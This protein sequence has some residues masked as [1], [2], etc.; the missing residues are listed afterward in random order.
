MSSSVPTRTIGLRLTR[1]LPGTPDEVYDAYTDPDA[2][3]RW[4]SALG[5]DAGHVR[6]DVDLRVGGTWEA[7]FFANPAV[8]VHDVFTFLALDPPRRLVIRHRGE[9]TVDGTTTPTIHTHIELEL[10]P[11][12]RGSGTVLTLA[13]TGFVDTQTRDFFE[14][15][16][17][18]GGLDRLAAYL[19]GTR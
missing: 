7:T 17:W 4:L 12:P 3:R 11:S 8:L 6:T 9:S 14:T 16:A 15:A 10:A 19:A 13:Q 1:E 18:P 5:P 2:Q